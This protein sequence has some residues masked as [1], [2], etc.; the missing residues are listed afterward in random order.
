MGLPWSIW[1]QPGV[2]AARAAL[3][4]KAEAAFQAGRALR[5]EALVELARSDTG[6]AGTSGGLSKRELEVARLVTA[7]LSNKDIAKRL[8]LSERTVESHV[9]HSMSKLG[10]HSRSQV[11]AWVTEQGLTAQPRY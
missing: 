6:K 11:A 9:N 3:G 2:E 5:P 10:V 8:F 7:G 1:V 4:A